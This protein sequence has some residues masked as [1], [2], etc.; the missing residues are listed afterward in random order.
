MDPAVTSDPQLI[1]RML[2]GDERAFEAFFNSYFP[3]VYRFALP[4]LNGDVD[5]AR[6][7]VQITLEKAIRKLGTFRGES[8]PLHL[9]L[10]D[11]PQRDRGSHP[12]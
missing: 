9:D 7:I 10:P 4:R 3:R 11:L 12:R 2:A 1:R 5:A 6:E 8:R